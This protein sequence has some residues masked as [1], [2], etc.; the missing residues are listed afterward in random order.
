MLSMKSAQHRFRT[1]SV[2]LLL[3]LLTISGLQAESRSFREMKRSIVHVGI[4]QTRGELVATQWLGTGFVTD[5][6][7]TV[8]TARH[9]LIDL[10]ATASLVLRFLDPENPDAVRTF[11]SSIVARSESADL[12]VLRPTATRLTRDFCRK[13]IRPLP[14]ITVFE[15]DQWTGEEIS[16]LGFPVLEGEQ[17]RDLPILRRG[18]IASAELEWEDRPM[19]LLDLTGVPGF[20]GSPV[21]RL[22]DG[23]VLG[24][25]HG[26]GLTSR[27]YDFEWATPVTQ[28][29]LE[30][31]LAE[32]NP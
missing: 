20:S 14:L 18:I 11:R 15:R 31:L 21:I 16:V 25:V 4:V 30:T 27:V 6:D 13:E 1:G 17:P 22:R 2:A 28:E 3:F 5:R 8:L 9:L 29:V 19:L 24:V 23:M 10:P 32:D 12:A 26:P 7:C